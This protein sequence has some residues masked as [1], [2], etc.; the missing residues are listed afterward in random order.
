M[1]QAPQ[2]LPVAQATHAREPKF[3]MLESLMGLD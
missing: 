1:A 2:D 3:I